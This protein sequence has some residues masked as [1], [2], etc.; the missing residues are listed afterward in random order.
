MRAARATNSWLA[1]T[2]RAGTGIALG[3]FGHAWMS[4]WARQDMARPQTRRRRSGS[5]GLG[6]QA[7]SMGIHKS[8]PYGVSRA[9]FDSPLSSCLSAAELWPQRPDSGTLKP[10]TP[11]PS[12]YLD[13]PSEVGPNRPRP[14]SRLFGRFGVCW[15]DP[16]GGLAAMPAGNAACASAAG[17]PFYAP[18]RAGQARPFHVHHY[19]C[20][21]LM[22]CVCAVACVQS[23]TEYI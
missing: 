3:A 1:R 7:N 17:R 5:R 19:L 2:L 16:F 15:R 20:R 21:Y 18:Q 11:L 13:I 6:A 14:L 10:L 9:S 12:T 22:A 8:V 23:C 4:A